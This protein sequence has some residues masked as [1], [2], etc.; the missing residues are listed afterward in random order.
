MYFRSSAAYFKLWALNWHFAMIIVWIISR[1]ISVLGI[2]HPLM[3]TRP[4]HKMLGN[5]LATFNI[6]GN[7]LE[8]GQLL[9]FGA[10]LGSPRFFRATIV[11]LAGLL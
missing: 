8:Y 7:F 1:E 2:S 11:I 9:T 5:F 10:T 6:C 4:R 3:T